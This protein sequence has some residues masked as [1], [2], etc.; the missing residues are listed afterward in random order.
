MVMHVISERLSS[1]LVGLATLGLLVVGLAPSATAAPTSRQIQTEAEFIS[2]DAEA[3]TITVKIRK[4]GK[5]VKGM[6]KLRS[7]REAVFKVKPEGSVLTRTTVKLQSGT[8]GKFTDLTQGRKLIIYWIPDDA[9]KAV[10]FARS[11]SVFIPADEVG[12]DTE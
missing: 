2:F 1:A 7:G 8:A 5:S 6:D 3:S 10:R 9:D 11:I 4:A 12:E